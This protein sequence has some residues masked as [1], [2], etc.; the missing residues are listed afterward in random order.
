M[1][2]RVDVGE[3]KDKKAWEYLVRFVFGGVVTACTGL[4]A[5]AFGPVVGGLFLGFPAI[6]PASLTLVE[7]RDGRSEA[8]DDGRGARLATSGLVAFGF[9]VWAGA[10]AWSPVLVLLA[11]TCAW[12]LVDLGLWALR[13]GTRR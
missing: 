8:V 1:R 5:H 4:V 10:G 13:Y 3:L 2:P 6:L 12:L 7:E 11:A 9:V